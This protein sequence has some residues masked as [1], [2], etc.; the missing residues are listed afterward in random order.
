MLGLSLLLG[1]LV[2]CWGGAAGKGL[3]LPIGDDQLPDPQVGRLCAYGDVNKDRLTDLIVQRGPKLLF[4]LQSED[5]KFKGSPR[6]GPIELGSGREVQCA[7]GDFNGDAALDV[8]VV[9]VSQ[10]PN[11][12]TLLI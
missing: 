7:T 3:S 12:S 2:L 10:R 6:H 1:L 4:L 9:T 11:P 5:G 8:L